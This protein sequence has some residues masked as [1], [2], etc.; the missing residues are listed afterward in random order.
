MKSE[1]RAGYYKPFNFNSIIFGA[2][3]RG[4][5]IDGLGNKITQSS[6]FFL[7]GRAVRGFDGGIIGPR[8]TG[9]DA[10]V[11]GNNYYSGSFELVSDLGL[12]KDLGMRWTVYTDYGSVWG[13]DYPTGVTG[14]NDSSMRTSVGVGILW[15][16]AIG[17][18]HSIGQ[19]L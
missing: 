9:N 14:A 8:D 12:S 3:I 13:T 5:M 18:S 1:F 19:M 11:G 15:D 4:G 10:S 2:K 7:G 6:R 16:T 17:A